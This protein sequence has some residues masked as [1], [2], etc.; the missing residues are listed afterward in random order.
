MG[1]KLSK[2]ESIDRKYL[3]VSC[4]PKRQ[5]LLKRWAK[6]GP[7]AISGP[8]IDPIKPA[9]HCPESKEGGLCPMLLHSAAAEAGPCHAARRLLH[10]IASISPAPASCYCCCYAVLALWLLAA[11]LA[12]DRARCSMPTNC[13]A[14]PPTA[15]SCYHHGATSPCWP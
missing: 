2:G 6:Y 12:W 3:C 10:P 4:L 1:S 14:H 5:T 11:R 13:P 9:S 8:P 15:M 7:W